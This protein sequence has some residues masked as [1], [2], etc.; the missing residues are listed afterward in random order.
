MNISNARLKFR[1][2]LQI[3]PG[4]KSSFKNEFKDQLWSCPV[5]ELTGEYHLDSL[6]HTMWCPG[7]SKLREDRDLNSDQDAVM[8]MKDVIRLREYISSINDD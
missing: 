3:V 6:S 8:Y 5:C 2:R 4:I 7:L 1:M